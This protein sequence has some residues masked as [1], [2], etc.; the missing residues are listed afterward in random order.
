M[1]VAKYGSTF[2]YR[3]LTGMIRN[4]IGRSASGSLERTQAPSSRIEALEVC[5]HF[6]LSIYLLGNFSLAV[7]HCLD[8]TIFRATSKLIRK[9]AMG[10]SRYLIFF[11]FPE[12]KVPYTRRVTCEPLRKAKG[13]FANYIS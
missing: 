11:A 13:S 1:R 6:S 9:R 10:S 4:G 2:L 5:I 7:R 3:R 8:A 12:F